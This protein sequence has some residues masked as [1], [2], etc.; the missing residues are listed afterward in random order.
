MTAQQGGG[1]DK[2]V[3]GRDDNKRADGGNGE[4]SANEAAAMPG[5]G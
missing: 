1:S 4:E 2:E 3:E 5:R